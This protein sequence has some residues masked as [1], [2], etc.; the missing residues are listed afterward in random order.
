VGFVIDVRGIDNVLFAVG[1]L[2][3]AERFYGGLLGL[4][5]T[6]AFREAGIVGYRL[7]DE[8]SGLM[9]REQPGLATGPARETPKVWLEVPDARA[10]ADAL[11]VGGVKPLDRPR[12]MRSGWF[13][14]VADPW[15]N[16]IGLADYTNEPARARKRDD[17]RSN[18]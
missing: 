11:A 13:V 8:A 12:E 6:F 10:G 3:E 14:E 5:T 2:G 4:P 1:D 15:G 18:T 9:L 17:P 7:G 16:V